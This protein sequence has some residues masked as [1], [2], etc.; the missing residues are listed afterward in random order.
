MQCCF[1]VIPRWICSR[2]NLNP[3]LRRQLS[4]PTVIARRPSSFAV[5]VDAERCDTS[6]SVEFYADD[7]V[8]VDCIEWNVQTEG[9]VL[10]G[11]QMQRGDEHSD[12]HSRVICV[13][14]AVPADD[15]EECNRSDSER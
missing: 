11:R 14:N 13:D 1:E 4:V 7:E 3:S 8:C 5:V 12:F 9:N 15:L 6:D 2:I 10:D